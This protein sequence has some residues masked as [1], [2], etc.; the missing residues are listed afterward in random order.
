MQKF[1]KVPATK[2]SLSKRKTIHGVAVNDANY[3]IN[4]VINGR[5]VTCPAYRKWMCMI[6]RCYDVKYQESHQTY[7]GCT[8][9]DDWLTFSN[10]ES[11]F[12]KNNVVGYHLDKDIKVKG[13]KVYSPDTCIF[14]PRS[15]NNIFCT[16]AS[17]NGL[18]P[19]G[20]S[21][22]NRDGRFKAEVSIDGKKKHLGCFANKELASHA[23]L[24]AKNDEIT[25]K[26]KQFK[27]LSSYLVQHLLEC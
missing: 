27:S 23:Y 10:F 15:L 17:S 3:L 8:V 19:V 22:D 12:R 16:H 21:V 13:N 24:M 9:C 25:R 1:I 20:V 2:R 6:R 14:I 5:K 7:V 18:L 26:C 11:W 4:I